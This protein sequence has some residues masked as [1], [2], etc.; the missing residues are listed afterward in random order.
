MNK[1]V[2]LSAVL[3]G[4]IVG[5]GQAA[6]PHSG[7][8]IGANL[9]HTSVDGKLNRSFAIV[10]PVGD[11]SNFGAR[12]PV[13]GLFL[14]YG[15]AAGSPGLYLGG[16]IFGQIENVNAKR[17]DFINLVGQG[18]TTK[19]QSKNTL[20]AVAKIGY[21]CKEMLF[22]GKLGVT[23]TKWQFNFANTPNAGVGV[24]AQNVSTN[25]RKTGFLVGIGMDYAIAKNWA[26]GAEYLYTMYGSLKLSVPANDAAA[27]GNFNYKPKVS[28]FNVRLKYTF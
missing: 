5:Q 11:N 16:E 8:S 13:F 6:T 25:S 27:A 10:P 15:W 9:G 18:F 12:S 19:L 4:A 14:G 21:V 23:T 17:E 28:T 1:K 24:G 22:F 20:G 3:A 26:I 2:L 7:F